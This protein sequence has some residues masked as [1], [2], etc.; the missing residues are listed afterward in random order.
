MS[1]VAVVTFTPSATASSE[2]IH[3]YVAYV[4][5]PSSEFVCSIVATATPLACEIKGLAGS[6]TFTFTGQA[7][8]AGDNGCSA[9]VEQQATTLPDRKLKAMAIYFIS[10]R[11][12]ALIF[13]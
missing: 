8:L 3:R 9:G 7:C 10:G 1:N 6:T 11:S 4:G 5:K 2:P 12:Y 13:I